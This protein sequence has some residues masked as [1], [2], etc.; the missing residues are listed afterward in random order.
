MVLTAGPFLEPIRWRK[1]EL[2]HT[3]NRLLSGG[4]STCEGF[5]GDQTL[6]SSKGVAFCC[7]FRCVLYLEILI[8]IKY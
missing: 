8:S 3:L 6:R 5:T 7:P 4:L 2:N 1:W